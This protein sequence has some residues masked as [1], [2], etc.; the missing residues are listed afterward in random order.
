MRYAGL[1]AFAT[2]ALVLCLPG[3]SA[4]ADAVSEAKALGAQSGATINQNL[5]HAP[6]QV[7]Q[8]TPGYTETPPESAYEHSSDLGSDGSEYALGCESN[9]DDPKCAV[10]NHGRADAQVRATAPSPVDDAAVQAALTG[11][12][13]TSALGGIAAS[14]SDCTEE[15]IQRGIQTMDYQYCHNYYLRELDLECKKV[16]QVQVDWLCPP[17]MSGP[18]DNGSIY[19]CEK[20]VTETHYVCPDDTFLMHGMCVN[21]W[22]EEATPAELTT[23]TYTVTQGAS[24]KVTEWWLNPCEPYELRTP[25]ELLL[26]DGENP[27]EPNGDWAFH[28]PTGSHEKCER[29][30]SVCSDLHPFT[31]V[32]NRHPVTR[33]CWAFTNTFNCVTKDEKSDCNQ[34][35]WGQCTSSGALECIDYDKADKFC[36]AE[37]QSFMCEHRNTLRTETQ[38]NCGGQ[39]FTDREGNVWD[40]GHP[41][42]N[43]F[44]ATI[45]YME[46]GRQAGRYMDE[47]LTLFNGF[48]NRCRKKLFGLVN[49]CNRAGTDPQAFNNLSMALSTGAMVGKAMVSTYMFDALFVSN[50]PNFVISGFSALFGSGTSSAL[51]GFVMGDLTFMQFAQSLMP[52]PWT[53]AMMAIQLSGILECEPDELELALKRDADLCVYRGNYCSKKLSFIGTCI[54][55]TYTYCC[56]NSR[57]AKLIHEQGQ[58]Q[59]GIGPPTAKTPLCHGFTPEQLQSMDLSQMDFTEFM[60]EIKAAALEMPEMNIQNCSAGGC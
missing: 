12:E 43:D 17:D 13:D 47:S 40:T 55:K 6:A 16:R 32:I 41:P 33:T 51:A 3:S 56:F 11:T 25:A 22:T 10:I 46:A 48:D 37:R 8:M 50:A 23:H 34:P 18:L 44:L 59:L 42:D 31:R 14:Y 21:Y 49:C 45:T 54:E 53:I 9:P 26:P 57:L 24:P 35:R 20:Q 4:L 29:P 7:Q 28:A 38:L 15:T 39:T 1:K 2:A 30:N 60:D 58:A 27:P 52:G 19:Y 36:T 5:T